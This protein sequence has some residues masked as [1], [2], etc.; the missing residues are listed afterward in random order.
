MYGLINKAIKSM[1]TSKFGEPTWQE[2]LEAAGQSNANYISMD[3]Y[4]DKTTYDLVEA[5]SKVLQ[6][7]ASKLLEGFGEYWM[8][9]TAEEGFGDLLDFSGATFEE[10]LGNLDNMH[11]RVAMIFPDLDPPSFERKEQD[12]G[13]YELHYHTLRGGLAPMVV[14]MVKGL[15]ARFGIDVTIEQTAAKADGVDHDVFLIRQNPA[16]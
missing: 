3:L 14:G 5:A 12:D 6:I 1:V 16:A 11:T 10:F 9:F 15:A 7:E 2:I 8:Q 4:E 13:S